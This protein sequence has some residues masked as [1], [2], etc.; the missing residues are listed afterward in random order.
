MRLFGLGH[1]REMT[2]GTL[3]FGKH[4][5][6]THTVALRPPT[7]R[8]TPVTHVAA[9]PGRRGSVPGVP[10]LRT[11]HH[12]GRASEAPTDCILKIQAWILGRTTPN[13][14]EPLG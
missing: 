2:K 12:W 3:S 11:E 8:S 9:L 14:R 13:P 1:R 10:R 7:F 4:H 5:N 6:E